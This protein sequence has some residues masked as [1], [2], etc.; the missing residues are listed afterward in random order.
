MYLY[1]NSRYVQSILIFDLR[2]L[3]N[4]HGWKF[5]KL[6]YLPSEK[7]STLKWNNLL[8]LEKNP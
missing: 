2:E 6:F 3:L 5:C 8:H 4:F 7:G 1:L